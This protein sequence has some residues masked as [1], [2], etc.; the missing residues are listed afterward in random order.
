MNII[1]IDVNGGKSQAI[2]ITKDFEKISF[3]FIHNRNGFKN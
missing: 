3:C 1:R 2:L